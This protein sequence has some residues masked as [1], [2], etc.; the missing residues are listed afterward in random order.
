MAQNTT[1][2]QRRTGR[3]IA[4]L[5]TTAVGVSAVV[6]VGIGATPSAASDSY[7]KMTTF[8]CLGVP[9]DFVVPPG[10]TSIYAA[11]TGAS[12][13]G[14]RG[15]KGGQVISTIK[16]RPGELLSV[17]VGCRESAK[18]YQDQRGGGYGYAAGGHG[19]AGL[20]QTGGASGGGASAVRIDGVNAV[21]AGGGGGQGA[22]NI[23][24]GGSGGDAGVSGGTAGDGPSGGDGG[25][26]GG[27][28]KAAGATGLEGSGRSG[29]GGGGGF[30][31][32]GGGG[33][34]GKFAGFGGGGGG[35]GQ[36]YVDGNPDR[37]TGVVTTLGE[38]KKEGSVVFHYEGGPDASP[39]IFTCTGSMQSYSIWPG[40]TGIRV[41][42]IGAN[43][44]A[45]SPEGHTMPTKPGLGE[46]VSAVIPVHPG[47]TMDVGVGC[48]GAAG[49]WGGAGTDR[50]PGG[51][52]GYGL[53][54]GGTGGQGY[55]SI[56]DPR[57]EGGG[58]GGSGGGGASGVRDSDMAETLLVG[59]GGGGGGGWGEPTLGWKLS[60]GDGGNGGKTAGENSEGVGWASGGALGGA[61]SQPGDAGGTSP[62][63]S[64]D[65]GGGGGGGGFTT[66]GAG[67][68]AG[69]FGGAGGGGGGGGLSYTDSPRVS[70]SQVISAKGYHGLGYTNG[71]VI[72]T[73]VFG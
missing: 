54:A 13:G 41:T 23:G 16:V 35:G 22:N 62:D 10:V 27:S 20:Y 31:Q 6:A 12:G 43:G 52:G 48:T 55:R 44:S 66:G 34:G 73:P 24:D 58:A 30:P 69:G 3:R 40:Q 33:G 42:A 63:G 60:G 32:G 53:F 51:Q 70:D 4:A 28:A 38:R 8:A 11:V 19:G 25:V 56:L 64:L 29:G 49:T 71:I 21:V 39:E 5:M 15:G 18:L 61:T 36:N 14:D 26:L 57:G 2:R 59:A 50:S 72:I 46:A 37:I 17:T 9:Q 45:K 7:E 65:G 1:V 68:N 47:M 67:G